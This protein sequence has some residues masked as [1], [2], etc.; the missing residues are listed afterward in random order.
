MAMAISMAISISMAMTIVM[1]I[2][3]NS[4]EKAILKRMVYGYVNPRLFKNSVLDKVS[5]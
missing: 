3:M 5:S 2:A 4:N 1:R